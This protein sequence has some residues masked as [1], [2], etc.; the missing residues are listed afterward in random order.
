MSP[1]TYLAAVLTLGILAQW[2]AW[3]FRLPSI[4]LLLAFG[5]GL[6]ATTG[7]SIDDFMEEQTLLAITGLFVAIILF[8]GGLTLK[9]SE[10]R[11]AGSPVV[12][13]CTWGVLIAGVLT[14]FAA[15]LVFG[16]DWRVA[17]LLG[18]ILV[19]TGPTVVGPLL[20]LIKPTR[21]VAS[22]VK[23][24][25]IVVDPIGAIAAVLV[26][27]VAISAG[28]QDAISDLLKGLFLTLIVGFGLAFS[29]A[30][31]IELLL[32]HHLI[33]D[34]LESVFLLA[35]VAAS[36]ALSNAV[37][38]ESGLLTV[39]LLGIALA[40]QKTVSVKQVLEFKEHLR[41][42]IISLLFILL[43]GRIELASLKSILVP[44][45]IF[46]ALLIFIVRPA[47]VLL[48]NLGSQQTTFNENL[49]LA[50]LAPR[51]IVAAAVA[52]IFAL[53]FSH[54]AH[55]GM[56]VEAIAQQA[57]QLVPVTFIVIIGTVMVY[58]LLAVPLARGLGVAAKSTKGVLFAGADRW[59]RMLAKAL[60]SDG[61]PVL[62]LDTKFEKISSAKMEGLPA[63]RANILS[64]FA[65]ENL[66]LTGIGQLIAATPNDEIN[67]MAAQEFGHLFGKANCWQLTP[68]DA[69]AH[70]SKAVDHRQRA[71]LC[72]HGGPKF[73]E[74]ENLALSG[75]SI[76][77]TR[78]TEIF[79]L[80]DF[81]REHG[82]SARILF[83]NHPE[84]GLGPV[85]PKTENLP[86][87]T[88]I[89]AL[90]PEEESPKNQKASEEE[91]AQPMGL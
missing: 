54:A 47:S 28:V 66:E 12:R 57:D 58:G 90:V 70:H 73:R 2:L 52:S 50:A 32:K 33:P 34:F 56:M 79:T 74:L 60:N 6:S 89:Y 27:Q 65:E 69:D 87:G 48:A 26:F 19:V 63:V 77:K 46:L 23:W 86:A 80:A 75:A 29:L 24:E 82:E 59:T 17:A 4:L 31:V 62:L 20:R 40:N 39:T 42:L 16:W 41:V 37:Q 85:E 71:R 35:V 84:K 5:F 88:Q 8:E 67:T 78:L 36:F 45:L 43:S 18:A 11:E 51:G 15:N 76:K 1:L 25:G 72:F 64:E 55:D 7:T 21:K 91:K 83:M 14:S 68:T 53:E 3:R 22:I 10:L 49:F 61:H 9:F 30:R 38:A 44:G 13:L 81:V